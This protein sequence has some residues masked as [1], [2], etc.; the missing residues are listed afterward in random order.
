M[1]RF[2]LFQG[3]EVEMQDTKRPVDLGQGMV[4]VPLLAAGKIGISH[5]ASLSGDLVRA[6]SLFEQWRSPLTI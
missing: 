3:S 6:A 1:E 5:V 2:G 4:D